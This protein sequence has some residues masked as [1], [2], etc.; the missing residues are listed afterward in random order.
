MQRVRW[1]NFRGIEWPEWLIR[2]V[3]HQLYKALFFGGVVEQL[4]QEV[5]SHVE[6]GP[7][8]DTVQLVYNHV[9][10]IIIELEYIATIV[11]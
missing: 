9:N 5:A 6:S 1:T 11:E 4:G 8:G 10:S 2:V 3:L 7:N